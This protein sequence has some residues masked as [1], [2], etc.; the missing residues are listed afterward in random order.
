MKEFLKSAAVITLGMPSGVFMLNKCVK[1]N[2]THRC[3]WNHVNENMMTR[4]TGRTFGNGNVT[5]VECNH[6]FEWTEPEKCEELQ[7]NMQNCV[8]HTWIWPLV[9]K[10]KGLPQIHFTDKHCHDYEHFVNK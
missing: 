1:W 4:V 8:R 2:Y 10:A 9:C 3:T 6:G 5:T 7:K